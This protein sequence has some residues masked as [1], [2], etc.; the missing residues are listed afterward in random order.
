MGAIIPPNP[1]VYTVVAPSASGDTSGAT[2]YTNLAAAITSCS[3]NGSVLFIQNGIYY[4]NAPLVISN[5]MGILGESLTTT[6]GSEQGPNAIAQLYGVVIIQV[7]AATDAIQITGTHVSTMIDNIGIGFGASIT[8]SNTGHGINAYTG[9]NNSNAQQLSRWRNIIVIGTDGN[10][11]GFVIASPLNCR[12]ELL[13]S[14]GGGGLLLMNQGSATHGNYGN[15]QF[16][17]FFSRTVNAGT[18]HGVCIQSNGQPGTG[19]NQF[20]LCVFIRPDIQIASPATT[21]QL[22]WNDYGGTC[23][24]TV[25]AATNA[26]P[27]VITTSAG[28]GILNGQLVTIAGVGNIPNGTYYAM[29]TQYSSTQLALYTANTI[30][31]A[32]A[33][34]SSGTFTAGGTITYTPCPDNILILAPDIEGTSIASQNAFGPF[35]Q[36]VLPYITGGAGS[37]NQIVSSTSGSAYTS[38]NN[39]IVYGY[40][41]NPAN[42]TGSQNTLV[43]SGNLSE[44]TTDSSMTVIGYAAGQHSLGASNGVYV[45][46]QAG[47]WNR[48]GTQNTYIG[49]FAGNG[50]LPINAASNAT[51]IVIGLTNG[52]PGIGSGSQLV[53]ISGVGGNTAANGW[54]WATA[55]SGSSQVNLYYDAAKTLPVPGNG[56][57]TSGGNMSVCSAQSSNTAVGYKAM[58][59]TGGGNGQSNTALGTQALQYVNKGFRNTGIGVQAGGLIT[60]GQFNTLLGTF[61]GYSNGTTS[62]PINSGSNN[63]FIGFGSCQSSTSDLSNQTALGY[64]ANTLGAYALALGVST[65]ASAAGAVAIGTD[66]TGAGASTSTQDAI[67]LGTANHTVHV[68]GTIAPDSAQTTLS[69]TTAGTVVWSQPFQGVSFKKFVGYSSGYENNTASNQT[70][71]FTTAFTNPPVIVANTTGLTLSVSTTA[72]TITA[73]NNTNTFSGNIII[74]GF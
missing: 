26:T 53:F 10:H 68:L 35:T 4:I 37:G 71:T 65:A 7:T 24:L 20:N 41:Q 27:A 55:G 72:L 32:V 12:F 50:V 57:Y 52:N 25:T 31:P 46:Q 17:N 66:H 16:D 5:S 34:T 11:Y 19:A 9:I 64:L 29:V 59:Y 73:P 30:L 47:Q 36:I 1:S 48:S 28:H 63:T 60:S 21:S 14:H 8:D 54:F 44:A 3:A 40:T 13:Y 61:A 70:I 33:Y 45:G 39:N 23:A 62:N 69:G 22:G 15:S 2:D 42:L 51:P 38:G 56:A 18:S 58:Q 74:E 43:G 49:N 67:A 6:P